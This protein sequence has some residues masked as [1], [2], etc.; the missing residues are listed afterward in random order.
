M[1]GPEAVG[2]IVQRIMRE[3]QETVANAGGDPTPIDLWDEPPRKPRLRLLQ[4][5]KEAPCGSSSP[6]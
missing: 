1:Q 4:G 3:M 6:D 2:T 5:G